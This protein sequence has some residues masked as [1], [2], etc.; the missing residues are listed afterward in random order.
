MGRVVKVT[1]N[2]GLTVSF[3]FGRIGRVSIFH[4]SDSY[5]EAP[6]EDFTP[7]KI[8]RLALFS[9]SFQLCEIAVFVFLFFNY[10]RNA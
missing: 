7:E 1:P 6:L 8:V 4:V 9:S 10:R 5:S 3:P 2:K